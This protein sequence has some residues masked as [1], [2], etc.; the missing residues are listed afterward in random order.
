MGESIVRLELE[1]P[2]KCGLG[3][4]Q[5]A[6]LLVQPSQVE[7]GQGGTGLEFLGDPVL[8]ARLGEPALLL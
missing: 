8:L 1:C 7:L 2:A 5:V 3:F 6:Q 4:G